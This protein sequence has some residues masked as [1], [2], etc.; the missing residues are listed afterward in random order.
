[1]QIEDAV[2]LFLDHRQVKGL[3]PSSLDRYRADLTLW[4][5]WMAAH[6]RC[7]V[8]GTLTADDFRAFLAYLAA[9]HVPH[10]NRR[11]TGAQAPGLAPASVHAAWR[12][13][14]A[15]WRF[16][17]GEGLLTPAQATYFRGGR[18]PAPR[19]PDHPHAIYSTADLDALLADC[20]GDDAELSARDRALI[21]LLAESGARVS[22][23]CSLVDAQI[24]MGERQAEVLGKGG[25]RRWI[26][27]SDAAAD[28][29]THYLAVRRG[30][31]G[32]PLFRGAGPKT[33]ERR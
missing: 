25:K 15:W 20:E 32:G 6:E 9:E 31:S 26:Y 29:L 18:I 10:R 21:L 1:M 8:V 19:I 23:I 24:D 12:T 28:A 2:R 3:R 5:A 16:L 14:R 22:E 30:A 33:R 7:R 17:D 4:Q 13:L 27:W 11:G